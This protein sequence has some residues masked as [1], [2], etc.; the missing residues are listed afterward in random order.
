MSMYDTG[1]ES[2][3]L[4]DDGYK[5]LCEVDYDPDC[6]MVNVL[7]D[8]SY[9]P[10]LEKSL[11]SLERAKD[12]VNEEY[13]KLK[14]EVEQGIKELYDNV[15]KAEVTALNDKFMPNVTVNVDI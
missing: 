13:Y 15:T 3:Q 11:Y 1:T 7:N 9:L 8:Y 4:L 10:E 14:T 12:K 6:E 5:R 2:G